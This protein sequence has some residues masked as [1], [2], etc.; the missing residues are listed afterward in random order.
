MS[1]VPQVNNGIS[2]PSSPLRSALPGM[3]MSSPMMPQ[4][5][6][7]VEMAYDPLQQPEQPQPT[8]GSYS[9][10]G[11]LSVL[12]L[13]TGGAFVA[14]RK[15]SSAVVMEAAAKD[16]ASEVP[17]V[18]LKNASGDTAKVYAKGACVTSYVRDGNETLAL[19]P[20]AVFDGSKPIAGGIPLCWPQFGP[21]AI[22]QHGFARN[23]LWTIV[24]E[25]DGPE[26]R[27]VMKLQDNDET[28][29]MWDHPFEATYTAALKAESLE[30]SLHVK[31]T[32]ESSFDFTGALHSYWNVSDIS[33]VK[34]EGDFG[35]KTFLDRNED[36][37][38]EVVAEG[39]EV[40]ISEPTDRLYKGITG[41][42]MLKDSG[43]DSCLTLRSSGFTDTAIWSPFGDDKMAIR[44]ICV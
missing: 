7:R 1:A 21:G 40:I 22:Q 10:L 30:V 33:K 19:R 5:G 11:W 37:P 34:V 8:G 16:N 43:S 29:A 3:V 36:P 42:V 23:M 28:R 26:D 41:D 31:N 38:K 13:A 6:Q 9:T 12:A 32:G 44:S 14:G 2:A 35:G 39:N 20:D 18:T 15:R 4:L 27:V 24:E 17:F 25:K